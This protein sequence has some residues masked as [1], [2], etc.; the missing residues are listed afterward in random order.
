MRKY[1]RT[2]YL[3][4]FHPYEKHYKIFDRMRYLIMFKTNISDVYSHNCMKIKIISDDDLPSKKTLT[5]HNVVTLIKSLFIKNRNHY[6][7][8]VFLEKYP[9][10]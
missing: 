8:Q 2:N 3:A 9:Y 6:Y 7:Y 5:I 10:K 1:D 4:L